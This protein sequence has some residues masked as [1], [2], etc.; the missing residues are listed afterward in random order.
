MKHQPTIVL[1]FLLGISILLIFFDLNSKVDALKVFFNYLLAPAP[2]IALKIID[3]QR[4]LG[5]NIVSF[6]NIHQENRR[7]KE[8]INKL[9]FVETQ[10]DSILRE[11]AN[12]CSSLSL[13]GK[14]EYKIIAARVISR[15]PSNWFRTLIIDKG[16]NSGIKPD[17]P[18]IIYFKDEVNLIGRTAQVENTTAKVLMLTDSVSYVPVKNLRTQETALIK[19]QEKANLVLDYLLPDSDI[20]IGDKIITSGIGKVFPPGIPVGQVYEIPIQDNIYYKEVLIKPMISW[21]KI[22]VVYLLTK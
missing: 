21:N 5:E 7:L 12:L 4:E 8:E 18:V 10:Y 17:M 1:T 2:E 6:V 15:D 16:K 13:S 19:G 14:V 11:N 9:K 20:K 3:R 22:G